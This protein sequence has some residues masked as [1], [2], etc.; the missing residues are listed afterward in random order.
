MKWVPERSADSLTVKLSQGASENCTDTMVASPSVR[1]G[2]TV[3]ES[4]ETA[5][6]AGVP[7]S[8]VGRECR[9]LSSTAEM[10]SCPWWASNSSSNV[11]RAQ[12]YPDRV[13]AAAVAWGLEQLDR[14]LH[15]LCDSQCR[16]R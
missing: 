11:P 13:P 5:A 9:Q 8:N 6:I 4:T 7:A 14:S 15:S 1:G 2:I 3:T 12:S 16:R 10:I